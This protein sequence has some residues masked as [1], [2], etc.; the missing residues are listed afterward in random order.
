MVPSDRVQKAVSLALS[1]VDGRST[2]QL[3]LL[4]KAETTRSVF[5]NPSFF[6]LNF[7]SPE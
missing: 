5:F 6:L 1:E 7:R 3:S 4:N 2:L